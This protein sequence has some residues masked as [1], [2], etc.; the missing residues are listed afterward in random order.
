MVLMTIAPSIQP[1]GRKAGQLL[2]GKAFQF[3][4]LKLIRLGLRVGRHLLVSYG[5]LKMMAG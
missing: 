4:T 2:N 1:I 3:A 5:R